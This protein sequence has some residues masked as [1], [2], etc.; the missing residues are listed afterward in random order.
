MLEGARIGLRL[1]EAIGLIFARRLAEFDQDLGE[2]R[3][4]N[5]AIKHV[6]FQLPFQLIGKIGKAGTTEKDRLGVVLNFCRTRLI[7]D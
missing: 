7:A 1:G 3:R 2:L 6:N 5:H 4:T